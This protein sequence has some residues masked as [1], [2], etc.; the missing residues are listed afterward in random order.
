MIEAVPFE[1]LGAMAVFKRLDPHDLI[2]AQL[3]RGAAV[4]YLTLFSN[5]HAQA[6]HHVMSLVLKSRGTPFAVL[7]VGNTGQAGVASA[8]LLARDHRQF[9]RE[10]VLAAR[11]IATQMPP[12]CAELGIHRIEARSWRDHPT[13]GAFLR[14]CGFHHETDMPGFGASGAVTFSQFAWI[15]PEL[16]GT[17]PCV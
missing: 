8:A 2:E 12:W 11:Q 3:T 5:W 6:P 16:K 9:R 1:D 15:N 13:A 17:D 14:A 7:A 4:T 10:L